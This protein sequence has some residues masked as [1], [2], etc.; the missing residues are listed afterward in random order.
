[1][2]KIHLYTYL[3]PEGEGKEFG[4]DIFEY[5]SPFLHTFLFRKGRMKKTYIKYGMYL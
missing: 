1:M 4:H 5:S 3:D 2:S